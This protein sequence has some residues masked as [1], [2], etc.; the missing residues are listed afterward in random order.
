M[1]ISKIILI[2]KL[3]TDEKAQ[4]YKK[5]NYYRNKQKEKKNLELISEITILFFLRQTKIKF[6]KQNINIDIYISEVY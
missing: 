1:A 3:N 5:K 2:S 6:T 4:I